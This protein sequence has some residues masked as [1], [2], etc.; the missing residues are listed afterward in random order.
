MHIAHENIGLR[1][2]AAPGDAEVPPS[3]PRR[4]VGRRGHRLVFLDI[5]EVWAIEAQDRLTFVHAVWGRFDLDVSLAAIQL[6]FA[7][8]LVRVHRNWLVNMAWVKELESRGG[9]SQLFIGTGVSGK[10]DGLHVPVARERAAGVRAT[11]LEGTA[12]LRRKADG[13][14]PPGDSRRTVT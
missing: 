5:D 14:T 4:I 6:S 13:V 9:E 2:S 8:D 3:R 1:V 11:L 7:R 10:S 12:G